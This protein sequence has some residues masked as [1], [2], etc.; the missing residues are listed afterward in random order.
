M[1]SLPLVPPGKPIREQKQLQT[2]CWW[3]GMAVFQY[4]FTYQEKKKKQAV[5]YSLLA[6]DLGLHCQFSQYFQSN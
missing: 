2:I 6:P 5:R 4:N 1:G 3:K